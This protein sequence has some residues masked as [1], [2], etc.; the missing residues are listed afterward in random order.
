[1][2]PEYELVIVA[3]IGIAL[4][5]VAG[6]VGLSVID[7]TDDLLFGWLYVVGSALLGLGVG[8][9]WAVCI[10]LSWL[11]LSTTVVPGHDDTR[12]TIFFLAGVLPCVGQVVLIATGVSLAKMAR[13]F[14]RF[15]ASG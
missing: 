11:P 1:L 7:M 9:W 5:A 8:R 2:R 15:R 14:R 13:A 6:N 12:G 3:R 4:L 10:A